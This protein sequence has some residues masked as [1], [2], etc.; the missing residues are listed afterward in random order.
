MNIEEKEERLRNYRQAVYNSFERRA[1]TLLDLID[2]LSSN[3][4]AES[5]VELSLNGLFRRQYSSITDGIDEMLKGE[6]EREIREAQVK[7]QAEISRI[8]AAVLPEVAD[9]GHRLIGQDATPVPR[10]YAKTLEDRGYV[11]E[12]SVIWWNTPVTIG[13]QYL[14]TAVL[15]ERKVHSTPWIVP[16]RISRVSSQQT[17]QEVAVEELNSL[18][19]DPSLPF[20][21]ELVVNVVDSKFSCPEYLSRVAQHDNL[22]V[23]TRLRGCRVLN[24]LPPPAVA[25]G[26]KAGHPTW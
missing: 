8:I 5:V 6:S 11:Y 7:Q 23:I 13:H 18:L 14:A 25:G 26:E 17:E 20:G 1:D 16:M 12:P 22:V 15:P 24:R 10:P 2:A 4:K 3:E 9:G 19:S 21:N